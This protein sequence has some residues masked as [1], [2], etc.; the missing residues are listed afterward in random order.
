[1]DTEIMAVFKQMHD[2]DVS[3]ARVLKVTGAVTE[4]VGEWQ[5]RPLD[6]VYPIVYPD[7]IVLRV[8]QDSDS[9]NKPA[10]LAPGI[11][12]RISIR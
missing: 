6:T 8:R 5:N 1:M 3:P 7:C 2:A 4:R 11:T 12:V 9:I 10:L